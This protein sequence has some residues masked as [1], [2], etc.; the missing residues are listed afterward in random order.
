[1]FSSRAFLCLGGLVLA[2]AIASAAGDVLAQPRFGDSTWVAPT[3]PE[4]NSEPSD[5]GPRVAPPER[6]PAW[7]TALRAPFRIAF[8]PL[9][10]VARGFEAAGGMAADRLFDYQ[11]AKERQQLKVALRIDPSGLLDGDIND[12]GIGP[13]VTLLDVPVPGTILDANASW[14]ISGRRQARF[15]GLLADRPIGFAVLGDY[16]Y[17]PD[18]KFYGIGNDSQEEDKSYYLLENSSLETAVL[19]G[20]FPL[21]QL[22][23]M[24]GISS[25]SPRRGS[26]QSPLLNEVFDESDVPFAHAE[27]QAI[28][29][30]ITGDYA[31]MD[32]YRDP[33]LGLHGKAEFKHYNGYGQGDPSYNNWHLEARGYV[34]VFEKRR[35]IAVRGVYTGVDPYSKGPNAMPFYR[36]SISEGPYRFVGFPSQRFRDRQ[37][38]LG[39]IEYRWMI[40]RR[41]NIAALYEIGEVAPTIDR[42]QAE[43]VHI[44]YGGG[45]RWGLSAVSVFRMDV[46]HSVEGFNVVIR[47]GSSL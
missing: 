25:I 41:L 7:E 42:F 44:S 1:M 12:I 18:R 26:N 21:R 36:L 28:I 5:S 46:A 11:G 9:R 22:R 10:L 24:G 35:V 15:V 45:L 20:K 43:D 27:T 8:Y 47:F 39:R 33:S 13:A 37:L 2:A 34:P 4:T 3:L 19:F 32:D 16:D 40:W 38:V 6:E 31:W 17:K 14:T 29:G 23:L 30:G